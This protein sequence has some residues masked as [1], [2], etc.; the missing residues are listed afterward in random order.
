MNVLLEASPFPDP[1]ALLSASIYQCSHP[2]STLEAKEIAS[3]K[4]NPHKS[5]V[6]NALTLAR[7]K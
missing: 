6:R 3:S 1:F 5:T 7:G 2:Q 4:I